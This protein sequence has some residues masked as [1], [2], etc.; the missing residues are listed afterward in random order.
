MLRLFR[1]FAVAAGRDQIDAPILPVQMPLPSGSFAK[2][3]DLVKPAPVLDA[4][5][6]D[7]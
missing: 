6:N 1:W 4:A 3:A 2:V 5:Y 7:P